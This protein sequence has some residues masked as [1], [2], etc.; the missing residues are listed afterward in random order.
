MTSRSHRGGAPARLDELI[1]V[2]GAR[3]PVYCVDLVLTD[4]VARKAKGLQAPLTTALLAR[5]L[6]GREERPGLPYAGV[7]RH[8]VIQRGLA[9]GHSLRD[10]LPDDRRGHRA[11]GRPVR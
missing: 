4:D 11:Q 10:E 6:T 9:R 7:G 2:S 5:C 3:G 1:G 8:I